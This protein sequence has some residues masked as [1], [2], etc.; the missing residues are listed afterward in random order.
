MA[1]VGNGNLQD[2]ALTASLGSS[3]TA[4]ALTITNYDFSV[5][6]GILFDVAV[7]L[8]SRFKGLQSGSV[9][10][11][12]ASISFNTYTGDLCGIISGPSLVKNGG[13]VSGAKADV[14]VCATAVT[15][16]NFG[17]RT[18]DLLT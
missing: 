12:N 10:G 5:L 9:L 15:L 14:T 8:K 13:G 11:V 3:N 1:N 18:I 17:I 7:T 2:Y 16:T 4:N 6:S